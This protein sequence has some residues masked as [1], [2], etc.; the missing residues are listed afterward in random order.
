MLAFDHLLVLEH[1]FLLLLGLLLLVFLLIVEE[2]FLYAVMLFFTFLLSFISSRISGVILVSF[3]DKLVLTFWPPLLNS[4]EI[5]LLIVL[6]ID[7]HVL[8]PF[9]I[10]LFVNFSLTP[11]SFSRDSRSSVGEVNLC[12]F[13]L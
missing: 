13:S 7:F 10:Y 12:C 2:D 1:I 11:F 4:F 5:L 3:L 6:R 9:L 8:F